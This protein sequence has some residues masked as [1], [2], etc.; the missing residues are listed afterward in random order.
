LSQPLSSRFRI[1]IALAIFRQSWRRRFGVRVFRT[2]S[3]DAAGASCGAVYGARR[4]PPEKGTP[5]GPAPS[6][7]LRP[8]FFPRASGSSWPVR[9]FPCRMQC[10]PAA[11]KAKI[12]R[13]AH[14]P[15]GRIRKR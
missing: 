3:N 4:Q 10:T 5:P 15:R 9:S 12:N 6:A 2:R 11:P 8:A 1:G 14:H 7:P 13:P